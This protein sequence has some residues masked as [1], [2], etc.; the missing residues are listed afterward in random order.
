MA[1]PSFDTE[2]LLYINQCNNALL[3]GV[4]VKFSDTLTWLLLLLV[5]VFVV[6]R[7]RPVKE[8]LCI[9]LGI[10]LCVLLADQISSSLIKPWV[11]RFRPTH[12][13][14]IMFM[15]RHITGRGGLYGFVSSH[16]ANTFAVATFLSLVFRHMPTT[17]SLLVWAS[18]VGYS[19]IYLGVHFPL[20]VLFG[21]LLGVVIGMLIYAL[22]HFISLK[23]NSSPQQYFSSAYTRS[24][25]LYDDIQLI[26]V[27][28]FLTFVYALF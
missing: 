12:D 11:A 25:F 16:A 3:D 22:L 15:V 9:L 14:E 4:M 13:P 17:V 7:D 21:A 19:R 27:A 1:F 28:L 18:I 23:L 24:G 5:V 6:L 26:L 8:A 10:G 2:L 20:D